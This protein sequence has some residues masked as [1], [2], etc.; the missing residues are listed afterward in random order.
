MAAQAPL[1]DDESM[2]LV[3]DL[4]SHLDWDGVAEVGW[5]SDNASARAVGELTDDERVE[6]RRLLTEAIGG[7]GRDILI[8]GGGH[9]QLI[10]GTGGG[11]LFDQVTF[12]ASGTALSGTQVNAGNWTI[13]TAGVRVQGP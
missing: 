1:A 5:S 7:T 3:A 11:V 12:D 13:G 2:G 10:G 6:L 9:D 8:G 4:A